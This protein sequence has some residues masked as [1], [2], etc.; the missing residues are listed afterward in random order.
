MKPKWLYC[1]ECPQYSI[2]LEALGCRC[3]SCLLPAFLVSRD[4]IV[5]G[6]WL[7][8]TMWCQRYLPCCQRALYVAEYLGRR[9]VRARGM[10]LNWFQW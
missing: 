9:S 5:D 10:T 1:V 3:T 2:R 7:H 4:S 8:A 6:D